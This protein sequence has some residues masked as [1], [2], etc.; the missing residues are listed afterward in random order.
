MNDGSANRMGLVAGWRIRRLRLVAITALLLTVSV[1]APAAEQAAY[2]S[3]G[4]IVSLIGPGADF[5]V[6]T[7]MVAVLPNNKRIPLQK[8]PAP[9]ARSGDA[10]AWTAP[11]SLADG[12]RGRMELKSVEDSLGVHYSTSVTAE[13]DLTVSAVEFVIDIPR[14]AFLKGKATPS[15]GQPISIGLEQPQNA[16]FFSGETSGVKLQD[17][18]A[19][20]T[21]DVS[22]DMPLAVAIVDR[23]DADGRYLELRARMRPEEWKSATTAAI[24][25]A[26]HF[27]DN[28]VAAPAR[29]TIDP[30]QV[31]YR[32]QGFGGNYCWDNR[33]PIAAYTL[34]NLKVSWA[35]VAIK[36]VQWDKERDNPGPE[37]RADFEMMRN[38]QRM[39]VPFVASVW[40]LPERFYTDAYEKPSSAPARVIDPLKW[41]QLFDL[42]VDYLAYAKREYGAE[43]DLFSFNESNIGINVV[44]T[45]EAHAAAIKR[46]GARLPGAG[47]KTKMLLGDAAGPR[48]T[49]KFTLEAASDAAVRPLAGAV[50]FHSWGGGS[51]EQY[52]AWGDLAEWLHLPLLVTEV[53]LDASAYS[54]HAWDSYDY[55]LREARMIQELL[56]YAR[57]QALLYWQFTDDYAL[58]RVLPDGSVQPSARFWMVKQF[59]DL[60][61]PASDALGTSSDQPDVLL[62]AFRR[63]NT[64]T[65]EILNSGAARSIRVTGVP[66]AE[67]KITQTTETAQYQQGPAIPST[68]G[69]LEFDAP[70]RSLITITTRAAH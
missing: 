22:F 60:I 8:R 26:L 70:G 49:H 13:T 5:P 65:L 7:N 53:G 37:L 40:T 64:Y 35:R 19:R 67:W 54:T 63:A 24:T 59:A 46:I 29:L 10:L 62:T 17:A 9:V 31:R 43:P 57:P 32:F 42:I 52:G 68:G 2:D 47:F 30:S 51:A 48:D 4:R 56:L 25:T 6:T 36:L 34:K 15:G 27:T 69:V 1:A 33:S 41:D 50:A 20:R 18:A 3:D 28:R 45:P 12:G 61:E 58:A 11:F 14:A 16:V 44:M 39:G 23:W 66:D 21:F 38:L 55:G